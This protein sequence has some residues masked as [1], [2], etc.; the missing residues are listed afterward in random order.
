VSFGIRDLDA[1]I[2]WRPRLVRI[3]G[4]NTALDRFWILVQPLSVHSRDLG[5]NNKTSCAVFALQGGR[6]IP[7]SKDTVNM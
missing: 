3:I 5:N 6:A 7:S 4:F 2:R 1:V